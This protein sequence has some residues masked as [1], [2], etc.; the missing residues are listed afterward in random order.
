MLD[1]SEIQWKQSQMRRKAKSK[2]K[3]RPKCEPDWLFFTEFHNNFGVF[4]K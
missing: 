2:A 3:E 4:Y 1:R